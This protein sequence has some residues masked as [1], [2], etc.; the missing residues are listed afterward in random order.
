MT[1]SSNGL[2]LLLVGALLTGLLIPKMQQE[3]EYRKNRIE[4]MRNCYEQ[5]LQYTNTIWQEFFYYLPIINEDNITKE[6]LTKYKKDITDIKLKRYEAYA[7]IQSLAI[8]FRENTKNVIDRDDTTVIE[9]KIEECEGQMTEISEELDQWLNDRICFYKNKECSL[10]T[11]IKINAK[12]NKRQFTPDD[13]SYIRDDIITK[14]DSCE[15]STS[16][17]MI[18]RIKPK[19]RKNPIYRKLLNCIIGG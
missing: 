4:L 3:F 16:I 17:L 18:E 12:I 19:D 2:V 7:K 13:I 11:H 1:V 5:F 8:A 6:K 15:K 9:E 10:A 14:V